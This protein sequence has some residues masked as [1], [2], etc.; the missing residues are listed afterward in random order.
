V[1]AD[2]FHGGACILISAYLSN[3]G[4]QEQV[5]I[6]AKLAAI[7][8]RAT[9]DKCACAAVIARALRARMQHE[10]GAKRAS[11]ANR[12]AITNFSSRAAPM[13]ILRARVRGSPIISSRA[14]AR[15]LTTRGGLA[16][17]FQSGAPRNREPALPYYRRRAICRGDQPRRINCRA[18][19]TL[20]VRIISHVF[21]TTRRVRRTIPRTLGRVKLQVDSDRLSLCS[22]GSI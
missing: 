11:R 14:R 13:S 15:A 12:R 10:R 19:T 21:T 18:R 22:R 9:S 20:R 4:S 16:A 2:F 5:A 6:R 3:V 8:Q 17:I 7:R 1:R